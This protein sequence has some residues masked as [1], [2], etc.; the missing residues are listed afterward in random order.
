MKRI[1]FIILISVG[2]SITSNAQG[3]GKFDFDKFKAEKISYIT[4][5]IDLTPEEATTF[6]PVYNEFE[7]KRFELMNE[8]RE[9]ENHIRAKKNE[10]S[11]EEL[12][13]AIKKLAALPIKDGEL[14]LKYNKEFLKILS[15]I[16]VVELYDAEEGFRRHLFRQ[17][18][19]NHKEDRDRR[20]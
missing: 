17:F 16:K 3:Q 4:E 12:S 19:E 5:A 10:L 8:R 18:R 20:D 11:E 1:I 13:E 6:W 9:L 15:P 14:A 7:K 2:I